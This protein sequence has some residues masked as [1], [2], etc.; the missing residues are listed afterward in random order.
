MVFGPSPTRAQVVE[1]QLHYGQY[2]ALGFGPISDK[3]VDLELQAQD[4]LLQ[5]GP[6]LGWSDQELSQIQR[7]R[8]QW[9]QLKQGSGGP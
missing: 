1:E 4:K 5:V 9:Q 2:K 7:A 8:D 6:R 3:V